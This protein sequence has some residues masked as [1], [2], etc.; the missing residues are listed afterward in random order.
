MGLFSRTT[1]NQPR[2][3]KVKEDGCVVTFSVEVP[4]EEVESE[5]QTGLLRI[6][7]HAHLP[8]FRP[9]KAPLELIQKN[10]AERAAEIAVEDMIQ[11]YVPQ[12]L[13]ELKIVPVAPPRVTEVGRKPG[14]PLKLTVAAEV[15]PEVAAKAY[16]KIPVQRK[17]YPATDAALDKRLDD[18]RESHARLERDEAA[19]VAKDHYVVVDYA[20]S[21]DG[22]PLRDMKG[23]GV[24]V[25]MT[26]DENLEGLSHGLLGQARGETREVK[27]KLLKKDALLSVTVR[28]IKKKLLPPLDDEFAKDLGFQTL[29]EL[30]T[31]LK[32]VIEK[33]G[34]ERTEREVMVQLE[35]ALLK[36]N[37]IPLPPS[38]V[39]AQ[40]ESMA[41]RL[42]RQYLG[43]RPW[44]S[45]EAEKLR[46]K[47]VP[48]A[49]KELRLS[50]ILQSIAEKEK[51][52]AL[53]AE[54]KAEMEHS[55]EHAKNDVEKDE[56]RKLF[57]ERKDTIAGIIR[58][59]KTMTFVK[60]KAL[61]ADA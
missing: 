29:P 30:K 43:D 53:D 39:E 32:E 14:E 24:L 31:A 7:A 2:F 40:V 41:E 10:Y 27:V 49:E 35:E 52:A 61:V 28:E 5:A 48:Q 50:Y 13:R 38:L 59:R 47:L 23:E 26:S 9:G 45:G 37:Q 21:Q 17:S 1:A 11:K 44:P 4:A 6:Q 15:A 54:I 60:E 16:T 8:G 19:A 51:L 20:A 25:D 3:K 56:L 55:L 57:E 12:A 18:L 33:E 46:P 36:A 22:K 42:R 34:K 58:D